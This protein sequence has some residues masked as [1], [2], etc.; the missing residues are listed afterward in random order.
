MDTD[1]ISETKNEFK[2]ALL[3]INN[4]IDADSQ[5]IKRFKFS[6]KEKSALLFVSNLISSHLEELKNY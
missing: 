3:I 2:E 6:P 1:K 5:E 4:V